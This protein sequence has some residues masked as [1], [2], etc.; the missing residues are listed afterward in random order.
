LA[1]LI[2]AIE[3]YGVV[4]ALVAV[5]SIISAGYLIMSFRRV[6]YGELSP[7]IAKSD[8]QMDRH[9]FAVLVIFAVVIVV[10]G[11]WPQ[12]IFEMINP[13]FQGGVQ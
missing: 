1:I 12:P 7:L 4:L 6:I 8:L 5:G 3:G 13:V 2:S 9:L 10:F 11:V